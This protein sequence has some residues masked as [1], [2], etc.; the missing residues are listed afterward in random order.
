MFLLILNGFML[1]CSTSC[2]FAL[3]ECC[4]F[5]DKLSLQPQK[6]LPLLFVLFA[7]EFCLS[8][9]CAT[10]W[11]LQCLVLLSGFVICVLAVLVIPL[12]YIHNLLKMVFLLW[13]HFV[14]YCTQ[15]VLLTT[16]V[17]SCSGFY[18]HSVSSTFQLSDSFVCSAHLSVSVCCQHLM[19]YS[20]FC[21]E[22]FSK[23]ACEQLVSVSDKFFDSLWLLINSCSM[24]YINTDAVVVFLNEMNMVYLVSLSTIVNILLNFTPHADSLMLVTLLWSS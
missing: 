7:V 24:M 10:S 9:P 11:S 20:E 5:L 4:L 12:G 3:H 16:V 23:L 18:W 2:F 19:I 17:L 14:C 8:D 15:T 22:R 6:V 1:C 13:F 21:C